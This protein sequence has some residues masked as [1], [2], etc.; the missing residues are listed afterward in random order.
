M[1]GADGISVTPVEV[2]L[3]QFILAVQ[4]SALDI[5]PPTLQ[6]KLLTTILDGCFDTINQCDFRIDSLFSSSCY[7]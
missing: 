1:L 3:L 2:K 6:H 7:R 4:W 5:C